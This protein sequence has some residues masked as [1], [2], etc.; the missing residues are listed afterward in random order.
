MNGHNLVN[1]QNAAQ[2][3][4]TDQCACLFFERVHTKFDI[5]EF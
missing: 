4:H 5:S 2:A 1:G 3:A